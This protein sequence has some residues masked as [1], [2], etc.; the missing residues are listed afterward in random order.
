MEKQKPCFCS[1]PDSLA[2]DRTLSL[3]AKGLYLLIR[4]CLEDPDFDF[5][6]FKP[7][8]QAKCKEGVG[9]FNSAWNEL[10]T[11]G[12]LKQRRVLQ[13]GR[14]GGFYDAYSLLNPDAAD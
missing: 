10:E 1:L 11:A 7:A 6:H 13:C 4:I 9:A 2:K 14:L 3:K 8:L 5:E 12:Y